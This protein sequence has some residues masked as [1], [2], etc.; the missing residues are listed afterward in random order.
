MRSTPAPPLTRPNAGIRA[1]KLAP[2]TTPPKGSINNR[3]IAGSRIQ[4]KKS[5]GAQTGE[6]P[7]NASTETPLVK[8]GKPIAGVRASLDSGPDTKRHG[9]PSVWA[10][11]SIAKFAMSFEMLRSSLH[12]KH[13][14]RSQPRS[15][16]LKQRRRYP[17]EPWRVCAR[18]AQNAELKAC[19]RAGNRYSMRPK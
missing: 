2:Q 4:G 13:R 6:T 11:Q 12:G 17:M 15:V 16:P 9:Q 5:Y 10:L 18:G 8:P 7:V 14:S 3:Q 1:K 19:S